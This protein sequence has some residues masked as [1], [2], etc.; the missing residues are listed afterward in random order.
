MKK[1]L[2]IALVLSNAQYEKQ[3]VHEVANIMRAEEE[4]TQEGYDKIY[5]NISILQM[6]H[7]EADFRYGAVMALRERCDGMISSYERKIK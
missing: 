3:L 6:M 4:C 7:E 5:R 2:M 1:M